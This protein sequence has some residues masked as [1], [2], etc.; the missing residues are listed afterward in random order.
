MN[1]HSNKMDDLSKQL[2]QASKRILELEERCRLAENTFNAMVRRNEALAE[3]IPLGIFTLDR[4]GRITGSN[5]KLNQLLRWP[6]SDT[7]K[8]ESVFERSALLEDCVV[9]QL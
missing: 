3:S 6:S 2:V 1:T 9:D 4:E 5:S 7:L 8:S